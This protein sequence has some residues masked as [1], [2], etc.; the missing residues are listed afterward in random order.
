MRNQLV[1]G[2]L[3]CLAIGAVVTISWQTTTPATDLLPTS[4]ADQKQQP[5]Q[6]QWHEA[7]VNSFTQ[8]TQSNSALDVDRD[9]ASVVVWD[10]RRQQSGSYG[11][12]LQRFDSSGEP[13]AGETQVN[14]FTRGLQTKPAVAVDRCGGAWV[15]WESF[16]QDGSMSAVIARRFAGDDFVGSDE[17][18]VNESTAGI[19]SDVVVAGRPDGGA[20][21]FW[22]TPAADGGL[23]KVVGRCFDGNGKPLSGEFAVS[24]DVAQKSPNVA[25]ESQNQKLPTV[26]TDSKGRAM[27]VWA[28]STKAG[29]PVG[30]QARIFDG[31][32]PVT[33]SFAVHTSPGQHIEPAV[34]CNDQKFAVAWL[35]AN[36]LEYAALARSFDI[37]GKAISSAVQLSEPNATYVNGVAVSM[38][39]RDQVR[40]SWNQQVAESKGRDI[41][42]RARIMDPAGVLSEVLTINQHKTGRHRMT[43]ASGKKR[44]AQVGDKAYFVWNGPSENDR[45]AV[46]LTAMVPESS[47][48][49]LVAA[50]SRKEIVE[51]VAEHLAMPH[52]PPTYDPTLVSRQAFGGDPSP[53]PQ[54]GAGFG[55]IGITMTP[56]N[57]PDPSLAA[58]PTHLV[59]MTNGAIAFFD[60][61]G[62]LTFQDEIEEA[63]G[64]WGA[65]GAG[66]FVFD[67]EVVYDPHSERFVAMANERTGGQSYFLLAISDDSDPNG[68]WNKYRFNVTSLAGNDIDSPNLAVD[69]QGVYLTADFFGPD[70]YLIFAIDKADLIAGNAN[71]ATE[72]LLITGSQSYGIATNYDPGPSPLYM[73]QAFEFNTFNTVRIHA[74]NDPL[75]NPSQQFVTV[76]VPSYGHPQDPPQQGTSSRPEL[77][78]ARFWSC[79]YRNGSLWAVHHQSPNSSGS[80]RAR[81]YEFELN[82]WPDSGQQPTLAQSGDIFPGNGIRTFFPSI[83]VDDAGNAAITCARSSP[84]EFISMS[85]TVRAAN[86]P[87]STFQPIEFVRESNTPFNSNRWGDYSGTANDPAALGTFWGMHEYATGTSSW[88]TWIAR[89]DVVVPAEDI[90]VDSFNFFRGIQTGGGLAS[91]TTSDDQYL[92]ANPG[93]TLTSSEAPVWIEFETTSPFDSPSDLTMTVESAA[94]TPNLSQTTELFNFNTNEYESIDSRPIELADTTAQISVSGDVTR[95]VDSNGAIE[96]RIGWR[97]AGFLLVFPWEIRVDQVVWTVTP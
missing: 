61:D 53:H 64:F 81:W 21:F 68:N 29:V 66:F 91:L 78:E 40:V 96:A 94:N 32:T 27:V 5:Q 50:A 55:F 70:E 69:E 19:Q 22:T 8:S 86:D 2:L 93:F 11:V 34:C 83:W 58:G 43:I 3:G 36:K 4:I 65:Q 95:F 16:G 6:L 48:F 26:A 39:A 62:N 1:L 52:D 17:I 38:D 12:Y 41:D 75:T 20:T 57:P 49:E 92:T 59:G 84:S 24:T 31:S 73:I 90:L 60:K 67:P 23:T 85:R 87:A 88:N 37:N 18:L 7:Q 28:E 71:P 63:D 79:V 10:S 46:N 74:I 25:Q 14:L 80:V 44:V 47:S 54:P 76:Q 30:I 33:E 15:A 97:V 77:F 45:S 42:V 51:N 82:G 56:W 13:I 9:G 35:T 89:Y 72:D